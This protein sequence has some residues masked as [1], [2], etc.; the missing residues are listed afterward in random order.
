MEALACNMCGAKKMITIGEYYVC[1]YCGTK[2]SIPKEKVFA[3]IPSVDVSQ[4][5][6]SLESDIERLLQQCRIDPRNAKKYA[7]LILDIDPRNTD[8]K[9]I[10]GGLK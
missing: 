8:A 7:N 10:L 5:G 1:S 3:S 2:Y 9:R 6:I 4:Q